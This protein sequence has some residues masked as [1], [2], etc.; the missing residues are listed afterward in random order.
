MPLLGRQLVH[1][2]E[3]V[4]IAVSAPEKNENDVWKCTNSG[5]KKTEM[6]F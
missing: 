3:V 1:N 6:L 5:K 2:D 4:E